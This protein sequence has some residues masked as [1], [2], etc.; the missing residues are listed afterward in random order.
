MWFAPPS[1]S[2]TFDGSLEYFDS[3]TVDGSLLYFGSFRLCGSLIL[4]IRSP[5][6]VHLPVMTHLQSM[7][8]SNILAHSKTLVL[9]FSLVRSGLVVHSVLVSHSGYMAL[10]STL[11][12]LVMEELCN[13]HDLTSQS[14]MV[15]VALS[16]SGLHRRYD[17]SALKTI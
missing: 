7:V 17:A 2:F 4:L 10:S 15:T 13:A 9:F 14:G 16:Y 6:M 11:I 5:W 8:H 12:N 3:L 1:D